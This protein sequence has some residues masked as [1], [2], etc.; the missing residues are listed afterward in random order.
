MFGGGGY[1]GPKP[2]LQVPC[3]KLL[4]CSQTEGLHRD[5]VLQDPRKMAT[6]IGRFR[7]FHA[8]P[9]QG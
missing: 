5:G 4:S 2:S 8:I 1:H 9:N 3:S 6:G 7:L